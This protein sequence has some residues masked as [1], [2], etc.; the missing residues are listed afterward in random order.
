MRHLPGRARSRDRDKRQRRRCATGMMLLAR[1]GR[2][3]GE[4]PRGRAGARGAWTAH[5]HSHVPTPG[6]HVCT[7]TLTHVQSA[8]SPPASPRDGRSRKG[9]SG[10]TPAAPVPSLQHF[11]VSSAAN[12]MEG[13][14]AAGAPCDGNLSTRSASGE[15]TG[16]VA[17]ALQSWRPRRAPT[18]LSPAS[19]LHGPGLFLAARCW[20]S[21]AAAGQEMQG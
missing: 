2:T 11:A 10:K 18:P 6:S 7:H 5:T 16:P 3:A 14:E 9:P 15:D 8:W 19:G 12:P 21:W 17:P 4:V 20:A 13:A 1:P